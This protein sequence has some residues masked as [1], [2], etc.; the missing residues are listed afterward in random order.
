MTNDPMTKECPMTNAQTLTFRST[1]VPAIG[2]SGLDIH[3][4]LVIGHWSFTAFLV[5]LP[6]VS[7]A[8]AQVSAPPTGA[9]TNK[10]YPIDLPTVLRLANA[11]NLDIQIARERLKEAK[12]NHES[13]VEQFFP[14]ISPNAAFRRHE[15]RIQAVDGTMLDVSRRK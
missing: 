7:T 2:H 4:S 9:N 15:N 1:P 3:W 11:Q 8:P 14:W 6:F 5:L 12:A 13:A 10:V